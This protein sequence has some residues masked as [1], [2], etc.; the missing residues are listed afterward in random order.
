MGVYTSAKIEDSFGTILSNSDCLCNGSTTFRG[1]FE[2]SREGFVYIT[3]DGDSSSLMSGDT[4]IYEVPPDIDVPFSNPGSVDLAMEAPGQ[5]I[6]AHFLGIGGRTLK[7]QTTAFSVYTSLSLYAPSGSAI[8]EGA[9]TCNG[10]FYETTVLLE[11][12][13]TYRVVV[14]PPGGLVVS[15]TITLS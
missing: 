3:F 13:G 8:F 5:G 14:S 7:F 2:V 6:A 9:C 1:P 4:Y 10:S 15:G 11:E 12:T